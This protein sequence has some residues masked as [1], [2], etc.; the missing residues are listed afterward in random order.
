LISV[1]LGG[2]DRR[3]VQIEEQQ[4]I[5]QHAEDEWVEEERSWLEASDAL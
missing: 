2:E 3:L 4:F 5:Q 1:N